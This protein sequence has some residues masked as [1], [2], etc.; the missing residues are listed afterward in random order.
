[1]TEFMDRLAGCDAPLWAQ[2]AAISLCRS[3]RACI[4]PDRSFP[5]LSLIAD[6]IGAE[7]PNAHGS[8]F[9]ASRGSDFV[10]TRYQ[11]RGICDIGPDGY[12][13]NLIR[14]HIAGTWN[15]K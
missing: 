13:A 8:N 14:G 11:I 12:V 2:A 15:T 7:D 10:C 4:S 3:Y 6:R 1:M 9:V 5:D